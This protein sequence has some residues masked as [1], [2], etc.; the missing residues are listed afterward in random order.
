LK[1]ELP[2]LHVVGLL[3]HND[4]QDQVDVLDVSRACQGIS[5]TEEPLCNWHKYGWGEDAGPYI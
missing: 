4:I 3:A 1:I 2:G 5:T